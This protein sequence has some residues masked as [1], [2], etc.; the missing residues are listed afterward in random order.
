MVEVDGVDWD[1]V[2]WDEVR[3]LRRV[4]VRESR[5]RLWVVV[6]ILSWMVW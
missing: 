5:G 3:V 1:E 2:D 4:V 6:A